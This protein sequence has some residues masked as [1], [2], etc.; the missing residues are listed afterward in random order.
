MDER[1]SKA[2]VTERMLTRAGGATMHEIIAATG[3]PQYNE[4]KRLA[5]RGYVIRKRK[6]G[7]ETRYFANAPEQRA[8]F[9]TM[10]T[11]K[12]QVTIPK[13]VRERLGVRAGSTLQFAVD[14]GGQVVVSARE[15]KISDL[16]GI[17]PKPKRPA[18]IEEMNE[19]AR[20]GAIS[21]YLRSTR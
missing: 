19:A 9:E 5:A 1:V 3:G 12:G 18:T 17:L 4:L 14:E 8:A 13:A 7:N 16:V 21:R 2:R 6:E 20:L 15:P 11:R 10:L